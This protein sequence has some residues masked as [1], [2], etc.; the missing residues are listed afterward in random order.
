M[1]GNIIASITIQQIGTTGT[2]SPTQ[3]RERFGCLQRTAFIEGKLARAEA[4]KILGLETVEELEY[5]KGAIH[6]DI[7]WG[8][9]G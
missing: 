9:R 8:L 3:V 6:K 7:Q 2:A 4:V 5:Q 1:L